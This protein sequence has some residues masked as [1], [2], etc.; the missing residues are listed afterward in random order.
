MCNLL[1]H[2]Q[3]SRQSLGL[4]PID[5]ASLLQRFASR[6][7]DCSSDFAAAHLQ[8]ELPVQFGGGDH[9]LIFGGSGVVVCEACGWTRVVG[10]EEDIPEVCA[11][12]AHALE[13][14]LMV[15]REWRI[16]DRERV[17]VRQLLASGERHDSVCAERGVGGSQEN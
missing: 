13:F 16:S 10:S 2:R 15:C 1:G 8:R 5:I 11:V 6:S 12:H 7:Q 4:Q 3:Q 14:A 9:R 17:E